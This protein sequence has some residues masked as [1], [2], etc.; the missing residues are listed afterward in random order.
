M[1]CNSLATAC[2]L[3]KQCSRTNCRDR[4]HR[5]KIFSFICL[6]IYPQTSSIDTWELS[7]MYWKLQFTAKLVRLKA[8]IWP[9]EITQSY[10]IQYFIVTTFSYFQAFNS[11]INLM[12]SII[13]PVGYNDI[14]NVIQ[15]PFC[16]VRGFLAFIISTWAC[17]RTIYDKT[18]S[19]KK[20]WCCT[21]LRAFLTA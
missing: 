13:L 6:R 14:Q 17:G 5:N 10:S 2:R 19:G 15:L 8:I 7:V 3:L 16:K 4:T 12:K 9:N 18:H 1:T 20:R 21:N 11:V